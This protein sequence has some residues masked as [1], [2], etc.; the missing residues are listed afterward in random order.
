MVIGRINRPFTKP[1]LNP[2]MSTFPLQHS[3]ALQRLILPMTWIGGLIVRNTSWD[4]ARQFGVAVALSAAAVA[5][6]SAAAGRA[7]AADLSVEPRQ[8]VVQA[9]AGPRET[10]ILYDKDGRPTVPGRTPYFHCVTGT[11]LLPGEIP[12]P[13]EYCCG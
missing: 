8:V 10:V 2:G 9:C 3:A 7:A 1:V 4:L 13:P 6:M 12:P 11:T 5:A